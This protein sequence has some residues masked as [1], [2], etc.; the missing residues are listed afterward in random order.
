[1]NKRFHFEPPWL[2][3]FIFFLAGIFT[4]GLALLTWIYNGSYGVTKIHPRDTHYKYTNPLLAVEV[5]NPSHYLAA[6]SLQN[7]IEGVIANAQKI[8]SIGTAGVYFRDI[9]SGQWV[10][11]NENF[12]FTPGKLLQVPL[13]MTYYHQAE[14]NPAVLKKMLVY[15]KT[16][17]NLDNPNLTAGER[18][19]VDDLIQAMFVDDDDNAAAVL[20]DG[21]SLTVL[22]ET[23]ADLG[24]PFQENKNIDDFITIK[25][26]GLLMRILYNATYLSPD[27][28]EKALTILA[29]WS[30][31]DRGIPEGLPNNVKAAHQFHSHTIA[32][33][34]QFPI[35]ADD[36]GVFY[37][38][39]H[40]YILCATASGRDLSS[41]N[42]LFKEIGRTA[43]ADMESK[44]PGTI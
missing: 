28:S 44:Y 30:P 22:N 1:M 16:P 24:I 10:G 2:V 21:I 26:Y 37:Y 31:I 42:A 7:K 19:A 34:S 29:K 38:P 20:F 33:P 23:Y 27:F 12:R 25:Y 9:E 35:E 17:G 39:S 15:Y 3:V 41:I 8:R 6:F 18:Y 11:I 4:G 5:N 40:P 43:Q 36:C 14:T 13:M 32:G